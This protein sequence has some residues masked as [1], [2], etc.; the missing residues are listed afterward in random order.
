M[1]T[2]QLK[3]LYNGDCILN[4]YKILYSN[5]L[6]INLNKKR[7]LLMEAHQI[8]QTIIEHWT[9]SQQI[10]LNIRF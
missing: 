9:Q 8:F 2:V 5:S 10:T 3:V 4:N 1:K 7:L 6:L